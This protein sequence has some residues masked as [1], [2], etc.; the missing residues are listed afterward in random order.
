MKIFLKKITFLFL[1]FFIGCENSNPNNLGKIALS[2]QQESK[3][4]IDAILSDSVGFN[5][6]AELCD[7]FGPR[8]SGSENLEKAILWI[9]Q[10]M[11]KD[12]I[13]NVISEEVMLPK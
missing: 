6:V 5:R 11:K 2:Y 1:L 3:K 4:I 7:T 8:L 9:M 12:G 10:E 13:E